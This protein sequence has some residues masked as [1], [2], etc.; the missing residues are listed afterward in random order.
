MEFADYAPH[1]HIS[2]RPP[3]GTARHRALTIDEAREAGFDPASYEW[4]DVPEG[5]W[6]GHLDFK[7]WSNKRASGP[8]LCYFTEVHRGRRFRLSAARPWVSDSLRYT[9]KDQAIDFSCAD[10]DGA[11]F[12]IRVRRD[13]SGNVAWVG[14]I[15]RD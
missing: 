6:E 5:T 4:R 2:Q 11:I 9:P 10:V 14:A 13:S 8:L 7:T 1:A 12:R 3:V 15:A